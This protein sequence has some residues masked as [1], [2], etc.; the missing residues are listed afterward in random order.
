[1]RLRGIAEAGSNLTDRKISSELA[2]A[3][4]IPPRRYA[5]RNDGKELAIGKIG[6]I[7]GCSQFLRN[8]KAARAQTF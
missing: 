3:F 4:G 8:N 6:E 1:M 2:Y 5:P 7:C